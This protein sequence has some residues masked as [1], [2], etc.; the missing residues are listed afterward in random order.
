MKTK[1]AG[2]GLEVFQYLFCKALLGEVTAQPVA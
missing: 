1:D 2:C